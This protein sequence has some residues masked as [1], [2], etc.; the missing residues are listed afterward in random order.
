L[1]VCIEVA[2]AARINMRLAYG[3]VEVDRDND[4]DNAG[5]GC[6][7]FRPLVE[8]PRIEQLDAIANFEVR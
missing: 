6:C 3:F 8:C 1:F 7:T 4:S 2:V 5:P